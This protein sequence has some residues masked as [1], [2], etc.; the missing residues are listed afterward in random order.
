MG[1]PVLSSEVDDLER[2]LRKRNAIC[3]ELL[4]RALQINHGEPDQIAEPDLE[5][6]PEVIQPEP[7]TEAVIE[8]LPIVQVPP[9]VLIAQNKIEQIKRIVCRRYGISKSEIESD[10]KI[11]KFVVPRQIGM[12][13][14]RKHTKY[15]LMEIARRFGRDDHSTVHHAHKKMERLASRDETFASQLAEI[16]GEIICT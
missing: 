11:P 16:S 12:H 7:L 2:V 15:S 3:S 14:A 13:L 8:A 10:R 4:L 1:R 5:P 6:E 9:I